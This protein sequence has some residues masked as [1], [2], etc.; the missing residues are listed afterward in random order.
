MEKPKRIWIVMAEQEGYIACCI[1]AFN[2]KCEALR[3]SRML[4]NCET[5][6]GLYDT[7]WIEEVM[8]H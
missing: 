7:V 4:T 3:Y 2:A 1:R 5:F 6:E 8:L